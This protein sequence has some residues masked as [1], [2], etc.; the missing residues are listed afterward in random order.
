[1]NVAREI[2][3]KL[4]MKLLL[5][6]SLISHAV[7]DLRGMPAVDDFT[8][9]NYGVKLRSKGVFTKHMLRQIARRIRKKLQETTRC[10]NVIRLVLRVSFLIPVSLFCLTG[11]P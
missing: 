3:Q 7:S 10:R 9:P 11:L 2:A 8:D 5:R 4:Q 6:S 1:M